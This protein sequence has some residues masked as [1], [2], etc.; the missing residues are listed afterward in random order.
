MKVEIYNRQYIYSGC[1]SIHEI[2][3]ILKKHKINKYLLVCGKSFDTLPIKNYLVGLSY[4]FVRFSEFSPNPKYEEIVNGVECFKKNNCDFIISIGGGSAIDVAKCIKLFSGMN[5]AV[6]YL[7]QEYQP[8]PVKHLTIPTT[9]G[10]GSE[11]TRFAVAYY[12]NEKKSIS[13]ESLVPDFVILYPM[14]LK[15]LPLYQKKAT[16]LDA[17]CQS[18]ESLWSVNST[19]E[20]ISYSKK[21][22]ELILSTVLAYLDNEEDALNY[23]SI[24]ANLSGRAINITQTTAAHAM[25]YKLT[26][27]FGLAHGHA[28]A[29][30]LPYV[31]KYMIQNIHL[32]SDTRGIKHLKLIFDILNELFHADDSEQAIFNFKQIFEFIELSKPILRGANQLEELV[33]SV[34]IE[35]LKNTPIN[36]DI[37]AVINIYKMIFN[38]EIKINKKYIHDYLI[39]YE[40]KKDVA[41]LQE[42]SLELLLVIDKF[43]KRN[44]IPYF[45]GEGTLL[46]AVRHKG[47]IPWDDDIDVLMKREDYE[48]F[49]NLAKEGL[50]Q[51]YTLDC[52]ETNPNHW[53][54]CAKIQ[55][56]RQTEF[57]QHR[58][59]KIALSTG[60]HIDI[61]PLDY[62]PKQKSLR[63]SYLGKKVDLLKVMLW[64]KLGYTN[65]VFSY[66][67]II[68]KCFGAFFSIKQ[69]HKM[70]KCT[71]TFYS[72][73]GN[74]NYLVNYGS[75]YPVIKQTFDKKYFE[76]HQLIDFQQYKLPVPTNSESILTKIYGD[77]LEYPPYS[78]RF[79]KHNY[80]KIHN[81]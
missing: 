23:M 16:M 35:R 5:S 7:K 8:V 12:E 22:I 48:K 30:C 65:K 20:S 42:Y 9:A 56:T 24:A 52:M 49:I 64:I 31:W 54:V 55:I 6:N 41:Q 37:V 13:H 46:G 3:T 15:T 63:Q 59:E 78:K 81:S 44:N 34:N 69:I 67:R 17:L 62:V 57:K 33:N 58:L 51:G 29:C 79:P 38:D 26:N 72:T 70:I 2:E 18:I 71:M 19:S 80:S 25:S 68:I 4:T 61:F 14:L 74:N 45:L 36:L 21:S 28:V 43:C 27:M 39:K 66:K 53:T 40:V 77:Y 32:C 75:M 11:S 76:K 1:D 73:K 10:S 50:P 47:F 60:P